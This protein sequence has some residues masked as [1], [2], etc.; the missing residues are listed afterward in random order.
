MK[1]HQIIK[2]WMRQYWKGEHFHKVLSR[3]AKDFQCFQQT[4]S[5]FCLEYFNSWPLSIWSRNQQG[6]YASQSLLI[7]QIW[8]V[9]KILGGQHLILH[10]NDQSTLICDVWP[11]D[12]NIDEGH[13]LHRGYLPYVPCTM[14]VAC[15]T[16]GS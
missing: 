6:S 2:R 11:C 16:K 8:W 7:S 14:F 10:A 4:R 9:L 13:L 5:F 12:L 15:L 1:V 3:W